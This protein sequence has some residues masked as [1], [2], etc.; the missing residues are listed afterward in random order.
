MV[1]PGQK[2]GS[3]ATCYARLIKA[4]KVGRGK[5]NAEKSRRGKLQKR[6]KA[7]ARREV[8]KER[9]K[10]RVKKEKKGARPDA[11]HPGENDRKKKKK[12]K[13]NDHISERISPGDS[14]Q[15]KWERPLE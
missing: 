11:P 14:P 2:N 5:A 12:K 10:R 13:P 15:N 8:P 1:L 9:E 3:P 6:P 4:R 7:A